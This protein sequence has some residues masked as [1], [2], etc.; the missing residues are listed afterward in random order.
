M[1]EYF[2]NC[3]TYGVY[4][5]IGRRCDEAYETH[6]DLFEAY[7]P[8]LRAIGA[9]GWHPVTHARLDAAAGVIME[10]FGPAEGKL[11]FTVHNPGEEGAGGQ[12]HVDWDA[13]GARSTNEARDLL[14]GDKVDLASLSLP[15]RSMMVLEVDLPGI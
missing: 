8:A 9:A 4:P 12:L 15:S 2:R 11:Y 5:S 14:T 13:L 3:T 7:L 10:R 6:R 1:E